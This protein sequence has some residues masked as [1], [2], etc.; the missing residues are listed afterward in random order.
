MR[1]Y[2]HIDSSI[3]LAA[4]IIMAAYSSLIY[5][6][7]YWIDI[8]RKFNPR[9]SPFLRS[10]KMKI[11]LGV[12]LIGNISCGIAIVIGQDIIFS[13][14]S[15]GIVMWFLFP[16]FLVTSALFFCSV[17][18]AVK[19]YR[20]TISS[21]A[22]PPERARSIIIRIMISAFGV[23]AFFA[24]L[25]TIF[26]K[27]FMDY[28]GPWDYFSLC[29][30]TKSFISAVNTSQITSFSTPGRITSVTNSIQDDSLE[31]K[32]NLQLVEPVDIEI[33]QNIA[34]NVLAI[35]TGE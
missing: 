21:T 26:Q 2:F 20:N 1:G 11:A 4:C 14:R 13:S 22:I 12:A 16:Y 5:V 24:C 7:F 15:I 35:G 33:M 29:F 3:R 25:V 23:V 32:K 17:H 10:F 19:L 34:E 30:V 9:I 18:N 8:T 31:S 6:Q 27:M 28:L